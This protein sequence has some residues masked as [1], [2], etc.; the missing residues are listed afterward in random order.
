MMYN[1][2]SNKNH[3]TFYVRFGE[4]LSMMVGEAG[5]DF[6]QKKISHSH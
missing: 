1:Y 5:K 4:K 2:L 3:R 6:R